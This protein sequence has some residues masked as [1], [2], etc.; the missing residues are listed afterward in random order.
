MKIL[1]IETRYYDNCNLIY[2]NYSI[3]YNIIIFGIIYYILYDMNF[4]ATP[5]CISSN[6]HLANCA[7]KWKKYSAVFYAKAIKAVTR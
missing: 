5:N 7:L 3:V 6:D 2:L 4:R 1:N